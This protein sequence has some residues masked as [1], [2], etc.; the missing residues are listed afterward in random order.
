[1]LL[2]FSLLG[3]LMIFAVKMCVAKGNGIPIRSGLDY[4]V[5]SQP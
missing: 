5:K 1:L 2:D 3:F 4:H